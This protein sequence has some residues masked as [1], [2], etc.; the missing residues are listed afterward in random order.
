MPIYEYKCETCNNIQD[1][2][3]KYKNRKEK[4]QCSK[5]NNLALFVDKIHK[6]NFTL[7]GKGWFKDGY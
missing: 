1:N 5:C 7:T 2:I 6:N 4:Q 3:V